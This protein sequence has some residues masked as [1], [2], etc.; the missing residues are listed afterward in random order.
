MPYRAL[1]TLRWSDP[2]P[3]GLK[4][5]ALTEA[6]RAWN[7]GL[8]VPWQWALT[9]CHCRVQGKIGKQTGPLGALVSCSQCG[10]EWWVKKAHR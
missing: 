5:A 9:C 4:Y 8:P 6:A 3:T 1:A 10:G 7:E 2:Y